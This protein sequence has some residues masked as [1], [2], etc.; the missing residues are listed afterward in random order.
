VKET[1]SESIKPADERE[2]LAEL[3][4]LGVLDTPPEE[5]FDRV[6]R[7]AQ[8]MFDASIAWISLVDD[9]RIWFKS[10]LG[11]NQE[12]GQRNVSFCA[13]TILNDRPLIV[14]DAT[15]DPRFVN[16]PLVVAAPHIRFFAGSPL[17]G[18][19]GYK[20]GV[21]G[22][23]GHM[24]RVFGA[25]DITSLLDL[26]AWAEL[27][28]NLPALDRATT[29]AKDNAARLR[30]IVDNVTDGIITI[31]E[32]GVIETFNAAA[33]WIFGYSK[34]E[35]AG[36]GIRKLIPEPGNRMEPGSGDGGIPTISEGHE[37]CGKRKDGA[38]FPIELEVS[39]MWVDGKRGFIGI[40][41]D[42]SE[43]RNS[44]RKLQNSMSLLQAVMDSTSSTVFVRDVQ[45]TF[46]YTNRQYEKLFF[47][48]K[49]DLIGRNIADLFPPLIADGYLESGRSIIESGL[50]SREEVFVHMDDEIL[51]H[52]VVR[53]PLRNEKGEIY[54]ICGVGTDITQRRRSEEVVHELNQQLAAT[55]A[56]QQ[57]ILNS[58]NFSIISTDM[59]GVIRVFNIGAQRMLGYSTD[60]MAYR[61]TPEILHDQL[62]IAARAQQLSVELGRQ[63]EPGFEVFVAKSRG[64]IADEHEWTYIRKDGSRFPVML[65]VTALW[66]ERSTL[67]GFLCIAYDLTERKKIENMKNEFISTVS[68]ELRTP[69][70]SIRGSL[71]LLAAGT[72]GEIPVPAKSLL[73]I[74]N[75]NCERLVRL[76]NDILDI[77]KIESGKMRFDTSPQRLLPLVEQAIVATQ[78]YAEQY[79]VR[80][81]LLP[82]I[83]DGYV[84]IDADHLTQVIINLLSNA[85]KFSRAGATVEVGLALQSG[86]M[87]LSVIDHGE[88]IPEE[89]REHIFQKFAQV[90]ASDTRR[91]EGT[92][93]GLSISKA[94]IEKHNGRIDFVSEP[95][96]RTEFFFEVPLVAETT[97]MANPQAKVLICEDDPELAD[98]L[99]T[100]LAQDGWSS[101]I[102]HDTEHARRLLQNGAYQAMTLDLVLPGEDGISL[103]HWM[104]KYDKTRHLP[105][106]IVSAFAEDS[107]RNDG[108]KLSGGAFGVVDWIDKPIDARRLAVALDYATHRIGQD[109]P[110]VLHVEDDSDLVK[111]VETLL[112]QDFTVVRA[113]SLREAQARLT[114][115]NFDLII[116]DLVLPDGNGADLLSSLPVLNATTPVMIFSAKEADRATLGKVN[117]ALVKSR[118]SNAQLL[119]IL[120]DLIARSSPD[121]LERYQ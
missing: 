110:R 70:T 80:F 99:A 114:S 98:L 101:D 10:R 28:L 20:I 26:A 89:F 17:Y 50:S 68:H 58:A 65:S 22:I 61:Q 31:D 76:I 24:P 9:E 14:E 2:R 34:Q 44:E 56:L 118:T 108:G 121:K 107:Q 105:V 30:A 47:G 66:D 72:V 19:N 112:G 100:L 13:H 111:V 32:G 120:H 115:Q 116:L 23:G 85:V 96:V 83:E 88:G 48:G 64:G 11:W 57:A 53:S 69:L 35:V 4:A 3:I 71:G 8:R 21:L 117:A 102:A 97:H 90:D 103:L 37:V 87:R 55:T 77:E 46:L 16:S 12:H 51:S 42:I 67:S 75:S 54:A 62:E 52:L 109:K 86:C 36:S 5:R 27:E 1:M 74:A 93:L 91:K 41:R 92:G 79:R 106:V 40:V 25:E 95:G 33:E 18:P 59:N 45:G 73:D 49:S 38:L 104:R 82:H 119:T 6:T 78:S 15:L 94:I 29:L 7:C 43:R 81:V 63:V 84:M 39:E 60:E 113:A